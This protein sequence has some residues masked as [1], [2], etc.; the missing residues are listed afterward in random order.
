[1]KNT[2]KVFLLAFGLAISVSS[3]ATR[4]AK[5]TGCE[6]K[7]YIEFPVRGYYWFKD[8]G[9]EWA[10][11]KYVDLSDVNAKLKAAGLEEIPATLSL[12]LDS[13]PLHDELLKRAEAAAKLLGVDELHMNFDRTYLYEAPTMTYRGRAAGVMRVINALRGTFFHGDQGIYAYRHGVTVRIIDPQNFGGREES[14][15]R[16]AR[17]ENGGELDE[18]FAYDPKSGVMILSNLG[19]QGDGL[20]MYV[21]V[22]Q[23]AYKLKKEAALQ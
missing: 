18:W 12:G 3:W 1:M 16:E 11:E 10:K 15:I 8:E 4:A 13:A 5:S 20:E 14:E 6:R 9:D 7:T 22:I 2:C 21:T 19:P 23:S 17:E